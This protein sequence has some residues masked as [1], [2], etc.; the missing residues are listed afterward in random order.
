MSWKVFITLEIQVWLTSKARH[1]YQGLDEVW[2]FARGPVWE[3]T[4][5][6]WRV[7]RHRVF[8]EIN[9]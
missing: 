3:D 8:G 2:E 9:R 5:V 6:V 4:S 1:P 7:I